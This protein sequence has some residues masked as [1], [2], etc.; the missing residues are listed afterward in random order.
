MEWLEV[1]GRAAESARERILSL[2]GSVEAGETFDRGAGGDLVKKV[3]LEAESAIIDVLERSGVSCTLI[4]EECGVRRIGGESDFY[5]VADPLD[6]TTNA[7]HTIPFFATSL[8]VA[9]G[10]RLNRVKFGLVM[11]IYHGVTFSAEKGRGAFHEGKTRLTPSSIISV[12]E[13]LVGI[14]L[15]SLKDENCLNRL[16]PLFGKTRKL[17]HLGA[18]ALE[19]CYVAA[20]FL[21]AF[22]DIRRR[23]RVTD[24]AASYLILR[25]AGGFMVTPEGLELDADLKPTERVSFVAAANSGIRDNIIKL[26]T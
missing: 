4:S 5:L 15:N 18:N 20:G 8:A 25:E 26:L 6:G 7:T 21:D 16:R 22:V 23:L 10:P 17:R 19:I 3:D 9:D 13:A 24:M 14:D 2:Y 11:D 12:E 1:L